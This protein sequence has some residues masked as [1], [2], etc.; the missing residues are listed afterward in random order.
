MSRASSVL[1]TAVAP[2]VCATLAGCPPR[3]P[4]NAIASA[5][6]NA[7]SPPPPASLGPAGQLPDGGMHHSERLAWSGWSHDGRFIACS[8]RTDDL[9]QRGQLT[10]CLVA[11]PGEP[12]QTVDGPTAVSAVAFTYDSAS[13]DVGPG[14]CR[15]RFDDVP[16]DPGAP[17]ARA[18]LIG[19]AGMTPL[20]SWK[21]APEVDGD[22]FA[23][24]TSLSLDG[25]WLAVVR[26][27]VGLGD[28][29]QSVDVTG[30]ELRPAPACR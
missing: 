21:P 23:L 16:G 27:A 26:V 24:E 29:E 6:A 1:L 18:T 7:V 19:P 20:A 30:I 14:A 22:Y 8:R 4:D 11:R 25:K 12:P 13:I 17:P 28:G 5:V 9:A 2:L 3:A 15:V 10:R